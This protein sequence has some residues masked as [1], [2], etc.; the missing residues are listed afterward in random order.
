MYRLI[1]VSQI[2]ADQRR[3]PT[4]DEMFFVQNA[5]D[6]DAGTGLTKS[7]IIQKISLL[8]AEE[9]RNGTFGATA[10]PVH[11]VPSTPQVINP[12]GKSPT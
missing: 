12:N 8:D 7:S 10:V 11:T 6:P 9:L 2:C 4:T 3:N 1:W 5:G